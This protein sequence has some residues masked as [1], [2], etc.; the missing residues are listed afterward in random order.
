MRRRGFTL[1]ELLVVI[2]II[3]ILAAILFPV[4]ARAQEKAMQANCLANTKQL[5]LALTQYVADYDGVLCTWCIVTPGQTPTSHRWPEML[6]PY[7]KNVDI[8]YCPMGADPPN[9][10]VPWAA[11]N[12]MQYGMPLRYTPNSSPFMMDGFKDPSTL[13]YVVDARN[14][15]CGC[16]TDTY[17]S[18]TNRVTYWN[19]VQF[20]HNEGANVG[21]MDGHAKW[22]SRGDLSRNYQWWDDRYQL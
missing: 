10:P 22:Q 7:V 4:F 13:I 5:L 21:F 16:Q 6:Q 1:I 2:A 12:S 8:F 17:L 14:M 3:A 19:Y 18:A 11:N 9:P 20:R 15:N